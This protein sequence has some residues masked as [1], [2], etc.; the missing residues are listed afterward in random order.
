MEKKDSIFAGLNPVPPP[1]LAPG[2]GLSARPGNDPRVAGLEVSVKALQ[3]EIAALKQAAARPQPPAQVKKPDEGLTQRLARLEKS[4]SE[5]SAQAARRPAA[6]K[7]G[8]EVLVSKEEL[9]L[10]QAGLSGV[11]A[12]F[13]SMKRGI[14]QYTEEF[15]GIERECR[16]SL[17]EMRGY[18]KDVGAKLVGERF[19]DYLKDSVTRMNA[20]L[21]EVE[22]AMHA[23]LSDL[24]GRLMADEVLYRKIFVEAEEKLRKGLEPDAQAVE[25]RLK[26]LTSKVTWLMDEYSIVM[27]RKMRALEAKYSAFDVLSARM[28]AINESL[29]YEKE[30]GAEK[31][32]P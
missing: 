15:A 20:K 14:A 16:K 4:V 27:E 21:A 32:K 28:D 19:D 6:P 10:A 24:S 23:G 8:G 1:P 2:P 9:E 29:Q 22:K 18:A 5:L 25:G 26:F 13:E 30:T 7:P 17:G 3:A 31:K 12:V 11:L